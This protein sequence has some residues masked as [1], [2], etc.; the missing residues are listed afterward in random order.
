MNDTEDKR[1]PAAIPDCNRCQHYYI[2]HH[3]VFRYG[4]RALGFKSRKQPGREV[5]AASGE[6]CQYFAPKAA[7]G[8]RS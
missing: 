1:A 3:A 7:R 2:T 8:D 5:L 6:P 4:C